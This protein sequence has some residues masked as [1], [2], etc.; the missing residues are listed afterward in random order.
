MPEC[1]QQRIWPKAR[2][3]ECVRDDGHADDYHEDFAG[4]RWAAGET[5]AQ[6]DEELDVAERADRDALIGMQN[7]DAANDDA[8]PAAVAGLATGLTPVHQFTRENVEPGEQKT[9]SEP[10]I[11]P[12]AVAGRAG[13]TLDLDAIRAR[14]E[15]ASPGPWTIENGSIVH[16]GPS[17]SRSNERWGMFVVASVGAHDIGRPGAANTAF[18]AHA[19]TDVPALLAELAEVTRQRDD[20]AAKVL[21]YES[22]ICFETSCTGCAGQTD[23]LYEAEMRAEKAESERDEARAKAVDRHT[24]RLAFVALAASP[25]RCR[26]HGNDFGRLGW[27]RGEP[28]C[29]SCKQPWRNDRA[30][31]AIDRAIRGPVEP[32]TD[33]G[34]SDG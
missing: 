24:L 25:Q 16:A 8:R 34:G 15:A 13:E 18:I 26:Y 3:T 28:R 30:L 7:W 31:S 21:A 4:N 6:P 2:P 32:V 23:R 14:A 33:D 27:E 11:G 10:A 19:R 29:D 9:R 20:L 5:P 1:R 22:A 12:A 17:E